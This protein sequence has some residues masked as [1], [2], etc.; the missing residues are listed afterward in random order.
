MHL[1]A[2]RA[3]EIAMRE[4]GLARTGGDVAAIEAAEQRMLIVKDDTKGATVRVQF[5][6]DNVLRNEKKQMAA[7]KKAGRKNAATAAKRR[8]ARQV[9]QIMDNGHTMNLYRN[10]N[11]VLFTVYC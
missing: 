2:T 9:P 11:P 3:L 4:Y 6:L 8:R 10:A 7:R 5:Q 1:E